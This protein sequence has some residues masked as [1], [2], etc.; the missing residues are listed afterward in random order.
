VAQQPV[1]R[2][3]AK[4]RINQHPG[5]DPT[6]LGKATRRRERWLLRSQWLK[7]GKQTPCICLVKAAL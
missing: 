4:F 3:A 1:A 6:G 2:P 5:F 7:Q